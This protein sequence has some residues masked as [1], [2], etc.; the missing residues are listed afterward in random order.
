MGKS[1]RNL[2]RLLAIT[3]LIR[4]NEDAFQ[5]LKLT[6]PKRV[7]EIESTLMNC[8]EDLALLNGQYLES[9]GKELTEG[10]V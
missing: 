2:I 10:D 3:Y 1:K 4:E 5:A 7:Q 8:A 6:D 9:R